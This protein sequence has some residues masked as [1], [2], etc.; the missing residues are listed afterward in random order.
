MCIRDRAITINITVSIARRLVL[1]HLLRTG[2]NAC[3]ATRA[4][5]KAARTLPK[6]RR[7]IA[8]LLRRPQKRLPACCCSPSHLQQR[9]SSQALRPNHDIMASDGPK[10]GRT[11]RPITNGPTTVAPPSLSAATALNIDPP[12]VKVSSTRS[13]RSPVTARVRRKRFSRRS[14]W[15]LEPWSALD[16]HVVRLRDLSLNIGHDLINIVNGQDAGAIG[17][18]AGPG[19]GRDKS[20]QQV[21][22]FAVA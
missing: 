5:S 11:C 10:F 9:A 19:L 21:Q 3:R 2:S 20:S 1:T 13:T 16:Q 12:R 18:L 22:T 17:H 4:R 15:P 14:V 6:G 8:E 7:A